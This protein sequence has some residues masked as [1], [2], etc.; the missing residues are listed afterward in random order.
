M[1][2]RVKHRLGAAT[3][4]VGWAAQQTEILLK[5]TV[6]NLMGL[7]T[8]VSTSHPRGERRAAKHAG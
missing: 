2:S 7:A 8:G 5:V 6:R 1:L 4:A 3:A